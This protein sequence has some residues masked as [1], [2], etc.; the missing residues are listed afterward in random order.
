M[1]N[2]SIRKDFYNDNPQSM[3]DV[4]FNRFVSLEERVFPKDLEETYVRLL[5]LITNYRLKVFELGRINDSEFE[6]IKQKGNLDKSKEEY[7]GLSNELSKKLDVIVGELQ[8]DKSSKL[9]KEALE[10]AVEKERI[11]G[12]VSKKTDRISDAEDNYVSSHINAN[13]LRNGIDCLISEIK[14]TLVEIE[15]FDINGQKRIDGLVANDRHF[16][17]IDSFVSFNDE[18]KLLFKK[19]LVS[20][21]GLKVEAFKKIEDGAQNIIS[22]YNDRKFVD[23]DDSVNLDSKLAESSIEYLSFGYAPYEEE[24]GLVKL[25]ANKT[26]SRCEVMDF[27]SNYFKT[28]E[29]DMEKVQNNLKNLSDYATFEVLSHYLGEISMNLDKSSAKLNR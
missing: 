10:I 22:N 9:L 4:E 1:S 24:T 14:N 19:M 11:D 5:N 18:Q 27:I 12:V 15:S 20:N 6:T 13:D 26:Y 25:L 17:V 3:E 21:L 23:A 7:V 16:S 28:G 29:L 2:Y 8:N